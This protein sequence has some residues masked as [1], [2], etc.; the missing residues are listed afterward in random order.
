MVSS[1][2]VGIHEGTFS[3]WNSY[4]FCDPLSH[5]RRFLVLE[6]GMNNHRANL[7]RVMLPVGIDH[8]LLVIVHAYLLGGLKVE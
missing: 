5:S 4:D 6:E 3:K 8:S 7:L 2:I 1:L